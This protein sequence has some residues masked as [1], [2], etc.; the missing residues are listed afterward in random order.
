M[1]LK[2]RLRCSLQTLASAPC[3]TTCRPG[4]RPS[5][6][7]GG[8]IPPPPAFAP[9]NLVEVNHEG[10]ETKG[11]GLA[12]VN[13]GEDGIDHPNLG[14]L[15]GHEAADQ[16]HEGDQAY[17]GRGRQDMVSTKDVMDRLKRGHVITEEQNTL[18]PC[19][20]FS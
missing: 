13:P 6:T 4:G 19:P 14:L 1:S 5:N 15:S 20:D 17:L 3:Q 7:C 2:K 9:F 10:R 16:G 12:A 18:S 8:T 11:D